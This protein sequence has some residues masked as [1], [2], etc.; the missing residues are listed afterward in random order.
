VSAAQDVLL[1]GGSGFM[2]RHAAPALLAA[3]HRVSVLSRGQREE[4]SGVETLIADRADAASLAEALEGRRF[5]LAVDFLAYG[6]ADIERLLLVPHAAL[7]R[8]VMISTGQV[9]L[10]TQRA[11]PPYVEDD[12]DGPLCPEPEPG[13]PDHDEWSYGVRKRRAERA[14]LGLRGSHGVRGLALRLPIVQGEG[15]GSLR[16]WAY[17][18][19]LLDGGPLLLP[20][21]GRQLT[22]HLY[23]GDVARALVWLAEHHEPRAACYNLAQPELVTLRELLERIAY[24]A[25]ATPRF[26]DASWEEIQAAGMD[27]SISPYAGRWSSVLDTSRVTAEW[28]FVGTRLEDYLPGVVRWHMD[29]ALPSHRGYVHRDRERELAARLGVTG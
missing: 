5:D 2:G 1:I 23:A 22:R 18:E 13:T 16:L 24:A 27:E 19:R 12:V 29:R 11:E 8:Y 20:D 17:L 26:V 7:G 21:G 6:A 4:I 25:G 9:Y 14:L 10:V 15:D 3:G 28:G